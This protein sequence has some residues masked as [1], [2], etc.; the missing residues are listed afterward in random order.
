MVGPRTT[1]L[2]RPVQLVR[3]G[4]SGPV[5]SFWSDHGPPWS[6]QNGSAVGPMTRLVVRP[7]RS[8]CVLET[9]CR[10]RSSLSLVH[11]HVQLDCSPVVFSF[12]HVRVF[13]L[14]LSPRF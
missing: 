13:A 8:Y 2:D 4:P 5:E 6:D 7:M 14:A 11:F 9:A 3:T 12:L 10:S 1:G